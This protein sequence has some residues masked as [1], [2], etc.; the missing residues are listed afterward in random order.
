MRG[1]IENRMQSLRLPIVKLQ[2]VEKIYPSVLRESMVSALCRENNFI[3]LIRRIYVAKENK[4][5]LESLCCF[6]HLP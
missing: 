2:R 5:F 3:I 4:I 1:V 6:L